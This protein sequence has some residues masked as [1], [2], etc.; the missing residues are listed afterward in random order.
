MLQ[1]VLH[2]LLCDGSV[3]ESRRCLSSVSGHIDQRTETGDARGAGRPQAGSTLIPHE[4]RLPLFLA[5][6]ARHGQES[7]GDISAIGSP[8]RPAD[9]RRRWQRDGCGSRRRDNAHGRRA[10]QQR[11]RWRSLRH[12]VGRQRIE[13]TKRERQEPGGSDSGTLPR[14]E[15]DSISRLGCC[16]GARCRIRMGGAVPALQQVQS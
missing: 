6:N 3:V 14:S 10:D 7:R 2:F 9:A 15:F 13:R 16:H 8:S 4:L 5:T 12:R 1:A 11:H